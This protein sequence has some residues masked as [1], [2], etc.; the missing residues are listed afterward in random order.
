MSNIL[1]TYS[2]PEELQYL[3]KKKY[4]KVSRLEHEFDYSNYEFVDITL[5]IEHLFYNPQN[6]ILLLSLEEDLEYDCTA[7]IHETQSQIALNMYPTI[8]YK[9]KRLSELIPELNDI[10]NNKFITKRDLHFYYETEKRELFKYFNKN[11]IQFID[12][13]LLNIQEK[14][15]NMNYKNEIIIDITPFIK[16]KKSDLIEY[17][18]NKL[19]LSNISFI[20]EY[21][22][23][24]HELSIYFKKETHISEKYLDF[25]INNE[26]EYKTYKI[27]DLTMEQLTNLENNINTQLIGHILFKKELNTSLKQFKILNELKLKKIFSIFLLGCS[28]IGKTEVARILNKFLNKKTQLIKINFGNYSSKDAINSLIGSPRGYIGSEDGELSLKLNKKHSGIILCDEFEKADPKIFSFFLELLEEGKFTDSQS[29]EYD[30]NGYVIIF[31]SN[32]EQNEFINKIPAEFQTRLD[33][34][35][36][37]EPLTVKDKE[38]FIQLELEKIQKTINE[39]P[40]YNSLNLNDFKFD[41][42]LHTINNLRDIQRK[43]YAQIIDIII[44]EYKN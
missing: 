14:L 11:N 27:C 33:L 40:K 36:E 35:S 38:K 13:S 21:E 34:I 18:I 12:I 22:E 24:N 44:K 6:K 5:A 20:C 39:H 23:Y 42:D 28:G 26:N 3:N 17:F 15:K 2:N 30:L 29:R 43:I 7:I 37:F 10:K 32:L 19:P 31:T 41:Y 9:T 25:K 16:N 8:F 1:Y 4:L